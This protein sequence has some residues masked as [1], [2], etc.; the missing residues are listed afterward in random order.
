MSSLPIS[1]KTKSTWN[2]FAL[3]AKSEVEVEQWNA[4]FVKIGLTGS[5]M[6]KG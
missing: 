1:Q 3:E 2:A 6:A 4:R 5:V